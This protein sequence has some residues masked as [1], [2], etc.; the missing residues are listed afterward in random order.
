VVEDSEFLSFLLDFLE[1]F[2]L[3]NVN[4]YGDDLG[5]VFFLEP[6]DEDGGV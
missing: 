6:F 2:L 4:G 3:S 5:V 1:V